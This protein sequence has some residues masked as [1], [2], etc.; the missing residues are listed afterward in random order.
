M[1]Q[2]PARLF[3]SQKRFFNRAQCVGAVFPSGFPENRFK[4]SNFLKPS[5][6]FAVLCQKR[7]YFPVWVFLRPGSF[8][9]KRFW[10]ESLPSKP[11]AMLPRKIASA[12]GQ[13]WVYASFPFRCPS[14]CVGRHLGR[15]PG[16]ICTT[17]LE[18]REASCNIASTTCWHR[19]AFIRCKVSCWLYWTFLP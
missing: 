13:A 6:N 9:L 7:S 18:K 19:T 10:L 11:L 16:V 8:S 14:C 17:C 15:C 5:V 1:L 3:H 4:K 12:K 2:H